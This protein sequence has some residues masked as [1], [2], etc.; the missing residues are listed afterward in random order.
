MRGPSLSVCCALFALLA[1]TAS[2]AN[3]TRSSSC[4]A[5]TTGQ[6]QAQAQA[7]SQ[8][9]LSH[10]TVVQFDEETW[11][12]NIAVRQ[13]GN[14]LLTGLM[15]NA[16]LYEVTNPDSQNPTVAR[17]F[18]INEVK[19]LLGI[20][21]ISPDVFLIA[22]GNGGEKGS[23]H[24]WTV[25]FAAG[26]P[27]QPKMVQD[28]PE[29]ML[30]NG[31]TKIPGN[32]N[33][34]VFISDSMLGLVWIVKVGEQK[35][36]VALNVTETQLAPNGAKPLG[37]NGVHACNDSLCWTNLGLTTFNKIQIGQDGK[38]AQ[39][40][41][42]EVLAKL[43]VSALDDFIMGP[44]TGDTAWITTNSPDNS[45]FALNSAGK[46]V[47]VAGSPDAL[48]F[49]T[50]TACQ[51]GRKDGDKNILYVSAGNGEI[52]GKKYGGKVEAIDVTNFAF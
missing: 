14:L 51:F 22:G 50:S 6:A 25:D 30:L 34:D 4:K 7:A 10:R 26:D 18:T 16:S 35:H 46:N 1:S 36:E 8:S 45:L 31:V 43:P 29:A 13:N 17:L 32:N 15:P 28:I 49:A 42:V 33:T 5:T 3:S 27:S 52:N 19:G 48:D 47:K 20:A 2:A 11:I 9:P 21:E 40:A 39:G 37:V 23:F 41:K 38:P 12:E 24:V 44:A